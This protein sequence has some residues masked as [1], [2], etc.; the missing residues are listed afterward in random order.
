LRDNIIPI[1]KKQFG[2]FENNIIKF[3]ESCDN[4]TKF[5]N[6]NINDNIKETILTYGSK[7]LFNL[8]IINSDTIEMIL[9][10]TMHRNGYNMVSHKLKNNFI[11]WL[12]GNK[13]NQIDLGKNMFCYY[14]NN[15]IY[16]VN[17]TKIIKNKPNKELLIKDFDNYLSPKIYKNI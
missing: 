10:N 9:L 4:Y 8:S 17:Y 15:Y 12:N 5:Y 6:D 11:Q 7:I 1:L 16:F 14:K 2:D 3:T 13:T